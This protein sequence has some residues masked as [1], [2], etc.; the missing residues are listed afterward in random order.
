MVHR[1]AR[2]HTTDKSSNDRR[3]RKALR[4]SPRIRL[5][6]LGLQL[7]HDEDRTRL[8]GSVS[9][10]YPEILPGR[11]MPDSGPYKSRCT[12]VPST[13]PMTS[14]IAAG[15]PARL[16]FRLHIKR[17]ASWRDRQ[18]RRVVLHHAVLGAGVC[19]ACTS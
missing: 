19:L 11:G 16:Q 7:H 6:H 18:N 13:A 17:L 8:R 12:A 14:D 4:S 9:I 1:I 15:F 3:N 10:R 5:T 2:A